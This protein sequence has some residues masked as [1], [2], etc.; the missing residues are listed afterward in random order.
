MKNII[1]IT[2]SDHNTSEQY[3]FDVNENKPNPKLIQKKRLRV[4]LYSD[5][6]M[7]NGYFYMH[8]N[9]DALRILK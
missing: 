8:A 9:K 7:G 2:S 1:F 5:E 4:I 3:Y 6:S